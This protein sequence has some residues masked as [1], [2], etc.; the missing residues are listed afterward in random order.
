MCAGQLALMLLSK[1]Y[2]VLQLIYLASIYLLNVTNG[3]FIWMFETCWK[4]TIKTPDQCLWRR[5]VVLTV[6]FKHSVLVLLVF[7]LLALNRW[8][9]SW[10]VRVTV[11]KTRG[12]ALLLFIK[13]ELKTCNKS[14]MDLFAK[15][16][17]SLKSLTILT[18]RSILRSIT[19]CWI[20]IGYFFQIYIKYRHFYFF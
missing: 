12:I 15:M 9:P 19:G 10:E 20:C 7:L 5:S 8:N 17:Y 11:P 18:R 2:S 3:N 4:L 13:H 14:E 6:N 16:V 1:K